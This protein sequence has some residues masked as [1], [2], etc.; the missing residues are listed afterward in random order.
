MPTNPADQLMNLA[1][2]GE[3]DADEVEIVRDEGATSEA[4]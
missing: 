1:I 3:P 4:V 2:D